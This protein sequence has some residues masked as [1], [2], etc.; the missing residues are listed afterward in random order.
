MRN[1]FVVLILLFAFPAIGQDIPIEVEYKIP[2]I[3]ENYEEILVVTILPDENGYSCYHCGDAK[4]YVLFFGRGRFLY[5]GQC[6]YSDEYWGMEGNQ[7]FVQ[8]ND[9]DCIRKVMSPQITYINITEENYDNIDWICVQDL[10]R[11]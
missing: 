3:E 10:K 9:I 11:P 5:H 8:W 4:D 6:T 2:V 1:L 7:L